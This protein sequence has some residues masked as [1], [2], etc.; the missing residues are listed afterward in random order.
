MPARL[1][2]ALILPFRPIFAF[3]EAHSALGRWLRRRGHFGRRRDRIVPIAHCVPGDTSTP[4][5]RSR[6]AIRRVS[7]AT[8]SLASSSVKSRSTSR[9]PGVR[10]PP[11][12]LCG[13]CAHRPGQACAESTRRVPCGRASVPA[14][15]A[16]SWRSGRDHVACLP[17]HPEVRPAP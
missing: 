5:T 16:R 4:A 15:A 8:S 7:R 2:T 12:A 3:R 9:L 13:C 1:L 14:A 10:Q 17:G 6:L 11:S